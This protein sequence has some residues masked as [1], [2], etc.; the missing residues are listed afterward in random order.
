MRSI[1][2]NPCAALT[3]AVFA[4][5]GPAAALAS[6]AKPLVGEA[7]TGGMINLNFTMVMQVLNF[8]ILMFLLVKLLYKPLLKVLDDRAAFVRE[9]LDR[10]AGKEQEADK[11]LGEY[12]KQLNE[13]RD[14]MEHMLADGRKAAED[15]KHRIIESAQNEARAILDKA[16]KDIEAQMEKATAELR[17]QVAELAVE[18]AGKVIDRNF[19]RE[20]NVKYIEDYITAYEKRI[21]K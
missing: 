4:L 15:E 9:S 17:G 3:A 18:I 19:S 21:Q 2:K 12:R 1:S 13:I 5:S 20:D 10:A 6:E 7:S 14:E 8:G 11:V 16:K